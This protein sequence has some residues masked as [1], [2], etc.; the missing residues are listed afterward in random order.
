PT[1]E[2]L[3]TTVFEVR[4]RDS[5]GNTGSAQHAVSRDDQ[6]P[7]QTIT[8]PEGTSMTYVNV[9]LD[10]ERTTYDGIYSQDT[11]TPDNV[12]ASRDFLKIDY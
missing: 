4:A 11:Y 10:G 2:F 9:G 7:A 6:A 5:K 1:D 12:Q 3:S 8:Y